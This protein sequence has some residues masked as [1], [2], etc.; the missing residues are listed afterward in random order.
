MSQSKKIKLGVAIVNNKT[1]KVFNQRYRH[2]HE[3]TDVLSFDIRKKLPTGYYFLG[4]IMISLD[5]T[6]KQAVEYKVT[7]AEELARVVA[8][9]V[10][11]LLGYEDLSQDE[12]KKMKK[13]EGRVVGRIFDHQ[14][15]R[16]QRNKETIS[17][18]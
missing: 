8:H 1:I 18:Q 13:I 2:V 14:E 9:G 10:L 3:S 7:E 4:D 5:Q 17:K 12:R 6:R 16:K 15:S 11:H